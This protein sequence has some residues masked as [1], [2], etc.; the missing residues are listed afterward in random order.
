[1]TLQ[2]LEYI[3]AVD[4]YKSFQK[5]SERCFVTQPT[6]SM[7]IQKLEGTLNIQIFDRT[8]YPVT[9]TEIGIEIIK[10]AKAVLQETGKIKELISSQQIE[11]AGELKVGIIP[12]IAPYLLPQVISEMMHKYPKLRLSV[13]E[14]TTE[15]IV[16]RLKN[17]LLDCGI[18]ATPLSDN[19]LI[20][21]VIYYEAFVSY[22]GHN[23]VLRNSEVVET[24][25]LM[26]EH[27]WLLNE[28]HCMRSQALNICG[29]KKLSNEFVLE[30]NSGSIETLI[31]MVDLNEG[32]T[33]LPELAVKGLDKEQ[34]KKVKK[35]SSPQPSREISIITHKS[36]VK[37]RMMSILKEEI[38]KA[39]PKEMHESE[40]REVLNPE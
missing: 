36:F 39:I 32:V 28:G 4:T 10:Q 40:N 35:F 5:A 23:S 21:H 24:S 20:E 27:I 18:L 9:T 14:N 31:K 16:T 13:W 8:T 26:Q 34:K 3:V 22:V 33:L 2:Q 30:Y 38:L 37:K 25:D 29:I 6:L 7:Q 19:Q 17:G 1:M 11:L 15:E 12:T